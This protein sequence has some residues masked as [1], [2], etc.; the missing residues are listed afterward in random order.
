M[1]VGRNLVLD[2][3]TNLLDHPLCLVQSIGMFTANHND[4][5]SVI[6]C[7]LDDENVKPC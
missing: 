5:V 3:A 7:L 4:F 6:V 2:L 1:E